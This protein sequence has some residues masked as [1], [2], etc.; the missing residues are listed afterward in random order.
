MQAGDIR[1]F[2]ESGNKVQLISLVVNSTLQQV[3]QLAYQ[4]GEDSGFERAEA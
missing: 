2:S 4:L 3:L 1:I